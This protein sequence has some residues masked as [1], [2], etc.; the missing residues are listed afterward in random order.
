MKVG[1]RYVYQMQNDMQMIWTVKEVGPGL[2]K[3]DVSMIMGGNPIGD[4]TAQEWRYVAP[5]AGA[6]QGPPQQ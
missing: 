2:V 5:P 4:P 3:Y 6:A 1:Q